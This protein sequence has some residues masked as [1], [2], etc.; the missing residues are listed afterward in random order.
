MRVCVW[1]VC[2]YTLTPI[3]V[4]IRADAHTHVVHTH[5]SNRPRMARIGATPT[6]IEHT[7]THTQIHST[8]NTHTNGSQDIFGKALVARQRQRQRRAHTQHNGCVR[9]SVCVYVGASDAEAEAGVGPVRSRGVGVLVLMVVNARSRSLSR[10]CLAR[11]TLTYTLTHTHEHTVGRLGRHDIRT[12]Y[13][14]T[15]ARECCKCCIRCGGGVCGRR[16]KWGSVDDY[17][18]GFESTQGR[19]AGTV[20]GMGRGRG[21]EW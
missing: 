3:A 15:L 13:T 8:N 6:A 19:T 10:C 16:G 4:P 1:M 14:H 17:R 18:T 12:R 9:M 7:K 2:V 20:G 5:T 11:T 21:G